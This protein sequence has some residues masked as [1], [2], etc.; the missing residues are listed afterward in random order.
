MP[1]PIYTADNLSLAYELRWSVAVFWTHTAPPPA[2][3]LPPLQ[4]VTEPDGVRILEHRFTKANVSQFLISTKPHVPPA[5][6]LR[7]VEGRLQHLVRAAVVSANQ[8][9]RCRPRGQ[10]PSPDGDGVI[11]ALQRRTQAVDSL[12]PGRNEYARILECRADRLMTTAEVLGQERLDDRVKGERVGR[13]AETVAFV[14]EQEVGHRDLLLLHRFD[15]LARLLHLHP[16]I[17]CA[18][19]NQ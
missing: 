6:C 13:A 7:S 10:F 1:D 14:C 19:S 17:V 11:S 16:R 3:W 15:H 9:R 2:S 5:Q 18:M 8:T 4:E 12:S